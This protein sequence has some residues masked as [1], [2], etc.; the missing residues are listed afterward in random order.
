MRR[1]TALAASQGALLLR[2]TRSTGLIVLDEVNTLAHKMVNFY[3]SGVV[4]YH[5]F[6]DRNLVMLLA[7]TLCVGE[8]LENCVGTVQETT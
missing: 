3:V 4:Y 7:L 6:L 5:N 2:S 1:L 8:F